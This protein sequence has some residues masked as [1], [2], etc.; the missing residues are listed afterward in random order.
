MRGGE[1]GVDHA[2][3]EGEEVVEVGVA[4][5]VLFENLFDDGDGVGVDAED[6][7]SKR[8]ALFEDQAVLAQSV[9]GLEEGFDFL[10]LRVG[11]GDGFGERFDS[12]SC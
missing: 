1:A 4:F 12:A 10:C 6:H 9:G 2:G 5:G 7:R 11:A 8:L 3:A